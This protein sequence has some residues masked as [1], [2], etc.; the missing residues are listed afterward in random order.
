M[1]E[2]TLALTA[3]EPTGSSY[4]HGVDTIKQV[5]KQTEINNGFSSIADHTVPIRFLSD[6]C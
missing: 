2:G 6:D 4:V 3:E 1:T 5:L